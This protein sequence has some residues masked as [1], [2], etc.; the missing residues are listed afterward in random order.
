MNLRVE[1]DNQTK[2]LH[3]I[4]G[5]VEEIREHLITERESFHKQEKGKQKPSSN[6][7][8][9]MKEPSVKELM[10]IPRIAGAFSDTPLF[11]FAKEGLTVTAMDNAHVALMRLFIPNSL[12]GHYQP[13]AES[14]TISLDLRVLESIM[15]RVETEDA[16]ELSV[17]KSALNLT[18][19][20]RSRREYSLFAITSEEKTG[21]IPSL[22]F[23]AIITMKTWLLKELVL[24]ASVFGKAIT[25]TATK[26][27]LVSQASGSVNKSKSLLKKDGESVLQMDIA[28]DSKATYSIEYLRMIVGLIDDYQICLQFSTGLPLRLSCLSKTKR[29]IEFYLAPRVSEN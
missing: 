26:E 15:K 27:G 16:I 17:E 12:L 18:L 20:G 24:D 14:T 29:L 4:M 5:T 6:L 28:K 2:L 3:N 9:Q 23:N 22:A 19:F 13:P 1:S 8:I 10:L 21:A 7:P 11:T 25:F